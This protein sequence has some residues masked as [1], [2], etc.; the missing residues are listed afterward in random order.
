[1]RIERLTMVYDADGGLRGEISY[2]FGVLRG[3]HCALCDITHGTVRR[4]DSFDD[5]VCSLPMP[6]DV[7]HRNEQEPEIAEFLE[8][9]GGGAAVVASTEAGLRI[10]MDDEAL[11]ACGGDVEAFSSE[12]SDRIE[13]LLAAPLPALP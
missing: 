5:L 11:T 3:R 1:M 13:A 8:A 9:S 6:V 12:L 2:V 4:K 10:L 7:V